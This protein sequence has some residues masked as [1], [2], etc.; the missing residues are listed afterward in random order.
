MILSTVKRVCDAGVCE[1][2]RIDSYAALAKTG[3]KDTDHMTPQWCLEHCG[4]PGTLWAMGHVFQHCEAEANAKLW[5]F[6]VATLQRYSGEGL[7]DAFMKIG[8]MAKGHKQNLTAVRAKLREQATD[9][10]AGPYSRAVG[11]MFYRA[12]SETTQLFDKACIVAEQAMLAATHKDDHPVG[13]DGWKAEYQIQ[14]ASLMQI[15]DMEY[16]P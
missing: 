5:M 15:L 10:S 3:R 14:Y 6:I 2:G 11:A 8:D 7:S 9:S 12:S 13:G 1:Q 4:V 16:R